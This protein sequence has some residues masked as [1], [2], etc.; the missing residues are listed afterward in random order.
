M[1]GVSDQEDESLWVH[2][3]QS[4]DGVCDLLRGKGYGNWHVESS[5]DGT[6]VAPSVVVGVIVVILPVRSREDARRGWN[7]QDGWNRR[8]GCTRVRHGE[9]CYRWALKN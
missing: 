9:Q 6:V 2:D 4:I 1:I 7:A 5:H 3:C 8:R